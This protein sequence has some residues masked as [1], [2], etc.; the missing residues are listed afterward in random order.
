[1]R[2]VDFIL[3]KQSTVFRKVGLT[4]PDAGGVVSFLA[5]S[6]GYLALPAERLKELQNQLKDS[7]I[8]EYP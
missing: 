6:A 8:K 4:N 3:P 2:P 7:P 5:L 1:M